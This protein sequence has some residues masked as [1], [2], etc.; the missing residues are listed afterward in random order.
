MLHLRGCVLTVMLGLGC[1]L[2]RI[3]F[4]LVE[5]LLVVFGVILGVKAGD[6]GSCESPMGA[7][8]RWLARNEITATDCNMQH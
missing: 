4:P 7:S 8:L 3:S 5:D 6:V 1:P 2:G